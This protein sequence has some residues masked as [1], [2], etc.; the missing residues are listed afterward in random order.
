MQNNIS[1]MIETLPCIYICKDI[2]SRYLCFNQ[3]ALKV[4]RLSSK[5]EILGKSDF[6]LPWRSFANRYVEQ[7]Q[8]VLRGETLFNIDPSMNADGQK[9]L[10]L[11]KKAPVFSDSGK[12]IAVSGVSFQLSREQFSNVMSLFG[13]EGLK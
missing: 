11:T 12:I 6:D 8:K 4:S 2:Q 13:S 5:D 10:L 7:D 3:E 9:I 1:F